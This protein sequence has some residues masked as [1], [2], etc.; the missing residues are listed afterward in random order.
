MKTDK[1]QKGADTV[2]INIEL[3]EQLRKQRGYS[4]EQMAAKLNYNSRATY[5]N[6]VNEHRSFT[7]ND[8]L[9]V[10]MIFDIEL[11]ELIKK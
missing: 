4:M 8:L 9:I 1:Q 7:L 6:K 11:S 5:C 2:K 10:S 3:I